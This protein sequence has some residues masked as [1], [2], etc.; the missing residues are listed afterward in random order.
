MNKA[1]KDIMIVI[2]TVVAVAVVVTIAVTIVVTII[3]VVVTIHPPTHPTDFQQM[4]RQRMAGEMVAMEDMNHVCFQPVP[5]G[6]VEMSPNNNNGM[7][8]QTL[9]LGTVGQRGGLSAGK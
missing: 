2:I 8:H 4:H 7:M 3:T 1:E 9:G 5:A 6:K